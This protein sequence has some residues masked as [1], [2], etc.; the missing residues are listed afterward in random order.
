MSRTH[1]RLFNLAYIN[2]HS[3]LSETTS[4][5]QISCCFYTDFHIIIVC[6]KVLHEIKSFILQQYYKQ[7]YTH[8]QEVCVKCKTKKS[9]AQMMQ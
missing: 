3:V 9:R 7:L 8:T 4:Y 6:T 5:M 1:F 2:V